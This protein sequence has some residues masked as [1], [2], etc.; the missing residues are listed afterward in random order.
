MDRSGAAYPVLKH[1]GTVLW[2]KSKEHSLE[3]GRAH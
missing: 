1:L 2:K 3:T